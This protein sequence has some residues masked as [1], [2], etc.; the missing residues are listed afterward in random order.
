MPP[1]HQLLV[2]L[3]DRQFQ[4]GDFLRGVLLEAIDVLELWAAE[5]QL[6][7]LADKLDDIR[8]DVRRGIAVSLNS[9][10]HPDFRILFGLPGIAAYKAINTLDSMIGYRTARHEAFGCA[11]ARLASPGRRIPAVDR[12]SSRFHLRPDR[13][14]CSTTAVAMPSRRRDQAI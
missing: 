12:A 4:Q 7:G 2:C 13:S 9:V 6:R 5:N 14:R 1:Q 11:A 10:R 8:Q 3:L